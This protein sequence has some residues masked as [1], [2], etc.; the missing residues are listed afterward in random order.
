MAFV[1][2]AAKLR[3]AVYGIAVP[4]E[5]E[6]GAYLKRVLADVIVPDFVPAVRRWVHK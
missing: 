6:E 3:A 5:G 2:S 1:A 4:S